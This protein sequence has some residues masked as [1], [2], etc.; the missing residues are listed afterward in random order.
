ML[1]GWRLGRWEIVRPRRHL[2]LLCGPSTSP[3]GGMP[4]AVHRLDLFADYFQLI[5]TDA[6]QSSPLPEQ[7]T[8]EALDQMLLLGPLLGE[9]WNAKERSCASG[10][11][12]RR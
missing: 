8:P 9:S 7:W 1:L 11:P 2:A 12:S 6:K 10:D 5:L 4:M 3:L